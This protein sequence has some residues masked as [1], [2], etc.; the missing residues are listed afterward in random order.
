MTLRKL[1]EPK[2]VWCD[3]SLSKD[4]E[5]NSCGNPQDLKEEDLPRLPKD[6]REVLKQPGRYMV[7]RLC[8]DPESFNEFKEWLRIATLNNIGRTSLEE[9]PSARRRREAL[10]RVFR[11]IRD[12]E[13]R[14]G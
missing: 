14:D 1:G 10:E 11:Q 13:Y 4:G 8:F 3:N 5:C 7:M 2:C 6:T 12:M 9:P